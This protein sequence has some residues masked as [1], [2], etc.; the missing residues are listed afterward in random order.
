MVQRNVFM[1]IKK[2]TGTITNDSSTHVDRTF[3]H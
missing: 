3:D 1:G 2:H